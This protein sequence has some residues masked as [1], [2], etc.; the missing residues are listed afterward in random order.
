MILHVSASWLPSVTKSTA[1]PRQERVTENPLGPRSERAPEPGAERAPTSP[2]GGA[3]IN[4]Q[5]GQA[6]ELEAKIAEE[7]RVVRLLR[8]SI[9]GEASARGERVRELG[10]QASERINVDFNV[11]DPNTPPRASQK[12]IAAATLLRAM[13]ALSSPKSQNLHRRR[14]R[15]SSKRPFNRPRARRLARASQEVCRTTA[16][17]RAGKRLSVRTAR[18]GSRPTRAEHRSGSESLTHADKPRT[19]TP[20]TSSTFAGR[21]TQRRGR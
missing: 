4:A 20:A 21:A 15:S 11:D 2:T 12:L 1:R 5:L 19:A 3:D 9:A 10:K 7:Y 18:Q 16:T 6:H 14:R 13:P 8:A 17:P